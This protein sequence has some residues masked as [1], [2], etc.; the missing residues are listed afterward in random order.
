MKQII[1]VVAMLMACSTAFSAEKKAKVKKPATATAETAKPADAPATAPATAPD[2]AAAPSAPAAPAAPTAVAPAKPEPAA[3]S[4]ALP[5]ATV[6]AN[7]ADEEIYGKNKGLL[8]DVKLGPSVSALG[9]PHPFEAGLEVKYKDLFSGGIMYGFLPTLTFS[10][11]KV[12]MTALDGRL[13]WHPFRGS[14]FMGAAYGTQTLTASK[15]DSISGVPVE[16]KIELKTSYLT[17]QLGWRWEWESG[18]FLGLDL[19][20]QLNSNAKTTL[21]SNVPAALTGVAQYTKLS[22]D[23]SDKGND[24]GNTN[25]PWFTLLHLGFFL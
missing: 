5:A 10:S 13:R 24:I 18:F 22:K 16:V 14:F 11:I 7:A 21:T 1:F 12:K 3:P 17:P 6:E 25:I 23:V 2:A 4:A 19:G 8:G 15:S 20:Y 9:F